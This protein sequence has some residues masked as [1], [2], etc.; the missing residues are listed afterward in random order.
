MSHGAAR[1]PDSSRSSVRAAA[2]GLAV[3][4]AIIGTA[5][6]KLAFVHPNAS[7]VWPP[8][9]LALAAAMLCGTRVW[10]GIL[11]GAL[12]TSF[13]TAV[14]V[15]GACTIAFG[16]TVETVVA[17]A[18]IAR[19]C[20]GRAAFDRSQ[21]VLRFVLITGGACLLGATIGTASLVL[22]DP[23]AAASIGPIWTTWWL[24][25]LGGMLLVAPA[26][27]LLVR[28]GPPAWTRAEAAEAAM[29][30][31]VLLVA[32]SIVFT[33][34]FSLFPRDYPVSPIVS[35]VLL[36]IAYRLGP[37]ETA[38]ATL[39]LAVVAIH[40]TL[41][42]LG[43]FSLTSP[44]ESLLLLQLFLCVMAAT[45][46]TLTAA[47]AETKGHAET[48]RRFRAALDHSQDAIL[49]IDARSKRVVDANA[50]AYLR[51]GYSRE[52]F[53]ALKVRDIETE[54]PDDFDWARVVEQ[55]RE[56]GTST[57]FGRHRRRDG[58][59]FPVE[60]NVHLLEDG[61]RE[62]LVAMVRDVSERARLTTALQLTQFSVD[63]AADAIFWIDPSAAITYANDAACSIL[64]Y[65]RDEL[66]ALTVH[67]IDPN[68]PP[69]AWAPHWEELKQRGSFTFESTHVTKSGSTLETEVTVNYLRFDDKEYNCAIMRDVSERRRVQRELAHAQEDLERQV[70]ERTLE[71]RR[72]VD[73]LEHEMAERQ[74]ADERAARTTTLMQEV[75]DTSPDW[76]FAKDRA[77]RFLFVNDAFA[78]SQ[79]LQP[80]DMIGRPDTD[81]WPH[82]LCVGNPAQGIRGFH[83]DDDEAF[84]GKSAH[85]PADPAT[86]ADGTIRYFDT[87]KLP[88]V[89][90]KSEPYG[91]LAYA[92]D[93][94]ERREAEKSLRQSREEL[95]HR[96]EERTAELRES[97]ARFRAL[98]ESSPD[99]I[100]LNL[101]GDR[102]DYINPAGVRLLGGTS[103]DDFVGLPPLS[104]VHPDFHAIVKE[105]IAKTL[106]LDGPVPMLEER[107]VRVDGTVIEVEVAPF[108]WDDGGRGAVCVVFRNITDR[109]RAEAE[110]AR[111]LEESRRRGEQLQSLSRRLIEVQESERRHLSS[112]LH[113]EIGQLLTALKI[114]IEI[115]WSDL[116]AQPDAIEITDQLLER[117]R[118][119]SLDLRPPLLDDL[120]LESALRAHVTSL[121]RRAETIVVLTV[122]LGGF[123]PP[124]DVA[125]ACYRVVQEALTNVLRHARARHAD[126]AVRQ[127]AASLR[128]E[129]RDDGCGFET[130]RIA[131]NVGMNAM[132]ERVELLGGEFVATSTPGA[133]TRIRASFPCALHS[134]HASQ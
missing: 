60:V 2:I 54:L 92:R 63:R 56:G 83:V 33:G 131:N 46:L 42:A 87:I 1:P 20:D 121:N 38:V 13:T 96:V 93:V 43:P 68:F 132:R 123:E 113:D 44:N 116:A 55:A 71:L 105:R 130:A 129:V 109:K 134:V 90:G 47:F 18:L 85:N 45:T 16:N 27:V 127:D 50:A 74:K 64:G 124:A 77:Y 73:R 69:A 95:E 23:A 82:E 94:T 100:L 40:G 125:L 29:L 89:D 62:Y 14:P 65:A 111:L 51:L 3:A 32:G 24:G 114:A 128:L 75:L 61:A 76:I 118:A 78:R 53:H 41:H 70:A 7:A 30:L 9:G 91:V 115:G 59:T 48:L 106:T 126:V 58:S 101:G 21:H 103:S 26:V 28:D 120:G 25:D 4:Y 81:F 12:L 10:P 104:I 39:L 88:L 8:A 36:W 102:I 37:R 99:G 86:L 15:L 84:A 80:A 49:L 79:G 122:D 35:A 133:G 5:S 19:F 57:F 107:F 52:A 112:E 22:G 11:V 31:A 34:G 17:A 97:E 98:V 117:V 66:L 72:T 119:I 6:L 67:D 108:P 110:R